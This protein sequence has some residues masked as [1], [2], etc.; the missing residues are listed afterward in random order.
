MFGQITVENNYHVLDF[1]FLASTAMHKDGR[2]STE[3][4]SLF[5][6]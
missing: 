4:C 1:S 6:A 3:R 2:V 5:S